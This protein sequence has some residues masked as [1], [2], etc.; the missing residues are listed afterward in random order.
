MNKTYSVYGGIL[1]SMIKIIILILLS[2]SFLFS[3]G[4][5]KKVSLQ[6]QWKHQFQFA[7]YYIAKEKGFYKDAGFDVEIKEFEYG[8]NVPNEI[9]NKN[10]TFGTGRPTILINRSH[11]DKL[12]L[13]A[14]IFQSS[15]NIFISTNPKIKTIKDFKNKTVM[16][17]GDAREDATILSMIFSNGLTI[18]DLIRKEHTFN[19]EDLINKKTDLMSSYISN[20]PFIL[21][22]KGIKHTIFD[23]KEYGFDFYNDLLFTTEENLTNNYDEVKA[24][25]LA[26]LKG[27]EYAFDN[28]QESINIILEKYNTQNKSKEA[29]IYEAKELKKLAFYKTNKLGKIDKAKIEKIY[30]YYRLMGF[31]ENKINFDTF[32]STF[33]N[34]I[35]YLTKKEQQY[36]KE[37]KQ[38]TM[39][40][41]PNWMP[42]EKFDE[43]GKYIG[44]SADY[45]EIFEKS[46]AT[47]F[48]VIP[49]SS[50]SESLEYAQAKKCD[51]LSLAMETKQR[52][53]YLNFTTP[54]MKVPLVVAT[55]LDVP[56][57]NNV[58]ELRDQKIGIPKG[59]AFVE[60]LKEQYPSLN[61]VEVEDINDGLKRLKK[62]EIFGYVGTIASISYKLQSQYSSDFKITGKLDGSWDLGVGVRDDDPVL[63]NI[64]QKAIENLS[65]EQHQ[66]ILNKW[67]S[68]KYEKLTDYSLVWKIVFISF[69]II[70]I[71][72]YLYLKEQLYKRQ[73]QKQKDEFE[74]IF[75]NSKDGIAL[76]DLEMR[77]LNFNDEYLKMTGFSK[78]ELLGKSCLEFTLEEDREN[79]LKIMDEVLET[80]YIQNFEKTCRV[81]NDRL[82]TVNMSLSLMPDKKRILISTKEITQL[83]QL[84]SQKKLASMGEMIGN[85]AHQWRQPLSVISTLASGISVKK[86]LDILSDDEF[87]KACSSIDETSQYLSQTIDD[88]TNYITGDKKIVKF[89]LKNDTDSFIKL[90]DSTIKTHNINVILELEEHIQVQ[91]Y[92]NELIQCFINIFNNAKDAMVIHNI[93]DADR[94]VVISQHIIDNKVHIEFKD[95]AGGIPEDIKDKIFEPYFTTKH[96][97]QGTGLGLH[98]TYN[99]IVNS[100]GGELQVQNVD[101]ECNGKSY[102]GAL[103]R[104]VLPLE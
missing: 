8:M 93:P 72:L 34:E 61:V 40:I 97:F 14:S 11:G 96:E 13:L 55:R 22:E 73:L 15:P 17:T 38:I 65:L 33:N 20:E 54:Y 100:M 43:T 25:T 23:P 76:L 89:N 79:S 35:V 92:P 29:L 51:I 56:F 88:F 32:V 53:E 10:A 68:I 37:K 1:M 98:M 81:K 83:K 102:E 86:E 7:G 103:F 95:T 82:I 67:V 66:R 85:I 18:N 99:L 31:M 91:G 41:D 47:P 12:V 50:W 60:I 78:E 46:I 21:K 74:T 39:C 71:I 59:Y 6:L 49:T 30:D 64:L 27:W 44:M 48:K 90:I 57:I 3:K 84:E 75:R 87:Y 28:I 94:F 77:F 2:F 19:I 70:V 101:F 63:F 36:L 104:I 24:F 62:G 16:V 4:N 80:G 9:K 26:S 42:F 5:E 58:K 45:F 52:S 69:M